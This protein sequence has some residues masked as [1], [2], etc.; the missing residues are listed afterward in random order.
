MTESAALG[1]NGRSGEGPRDESM[2]RLL[3]SGFHGDLY[4]H[5][6]V[7]S[8]V[9]HAD[10][11][12]ETGTNVGSTTRHVA[13][14]WPG[15]EVHSCEPNRA[16]FERARRHLEGLGSVTLHQKASPGFLHDLLRERPGLAGRTPLCWLDAHAPG[17]AWPILEEVSFIT[18]RFRA[19]MILV[20]DCRVPGREAFGYDEYDGVACEPGYVLPAVRREGARV[21]LPA[22]T[23]HTSGHHPLRGVMLIV[24]GVGWR[25]PG[26]LEGSFEVF[27]PASLMAA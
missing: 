18:E 9:P 11:F 1:V 7:E 13:A 14:R 21:V 23:E 20:D 2:L 12:L 19:G 26:A 25:L 6:L 22:Y 3:P 5:R 24:F 27:E 16:S 4:L 17:V 10:L 15:L 8:L